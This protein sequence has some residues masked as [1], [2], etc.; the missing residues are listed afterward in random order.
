L[1][2]RKIY[3]WNGVCEDLYLL[4]EDVAECVFRL[5]NAYKSSL[6][7][8]GAESDPGM[9]ETQFYDFPA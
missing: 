1:A 6:G 8:S 2:Q 9:S 4:H 7:A 5:P 3:A